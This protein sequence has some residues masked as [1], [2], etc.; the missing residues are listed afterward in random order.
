MKLLFLI[1]KKAKATDLETLAPIYVRM[2]E[3]R[4]FDKWIP[5]RIIVN[6]NYWDSREEC[7]KKRNKRIKLNIDTITH[8]DLA[9]I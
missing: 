2:R 7:V 6:P 1:R 4:K 3:G 8:D 5:S 9:A